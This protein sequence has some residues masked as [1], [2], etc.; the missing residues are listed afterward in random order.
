M[1]TKFEM[2][3]EY[4]WSAY[5]QRIKNRDESFDFLK[6]FKKQIL[7]Y[8][9]IPEED[10]KFFPIEDNPMDYYE[11][12]KGKQSNLHVFSL[13][14]DGFF[15]IGFSFKV[16]KAKNVFPNTI[17]NFKMKFRKCNE[18]FKLKFGNTEKLFDVLPDE[19]GSFIEALDFICNLVEKYFSNENVHI[20]ESGK[21]TK[22]G[23][24]SEV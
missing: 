5:E 3:C 14:E 16:Y 12:Q 24:I 2:M 8:L 17:L 18:V 6:K 21:S 13:S 4:Y 20:E 19:Q 22:I 15:N 7:E 9:M 10:L 1:K 23:Y 11:D